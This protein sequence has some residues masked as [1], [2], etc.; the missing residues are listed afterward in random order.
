MAISTVG[1]TANAQNVPAPDGS[2]EEIEKIVVLGEKANRTLKDS[3]SSISVLTADEINNTQYKS[4]SDALSEIAN[5]VTLSAH[6]PTFAVF[7]ETVAQGAL[8]QSPV[9]QRG[10]YRP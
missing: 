5:V 4:V 10:A 7:Q 3:T 2:V 1:F 6:C 8:I 9:A